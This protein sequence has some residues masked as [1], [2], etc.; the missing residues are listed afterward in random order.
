METRAIARPDL[1]A[2]P[3]AAILWETTTRAPSNF[4]RR[5]VFTKN[6]SMNTKTCSLR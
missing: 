1:T 4:L 5:C 6:R 2:T 3:L